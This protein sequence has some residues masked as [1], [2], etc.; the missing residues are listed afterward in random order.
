MQVCSLHM[1][2]TNYL[3]TTCEVLQPFDKNKQDHADPEGSQC[4]TG[5]H[6]IK[7]KADISLWF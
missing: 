6:Q 1:Y 4:L 2:N 3:I 5:N 7:Q